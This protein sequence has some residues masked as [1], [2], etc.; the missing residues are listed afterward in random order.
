MAST[1]YTD[2]GYVS[3]YGGGIL[4]AREV[5]DTGLPMTITITGISKASTAVVSTAETNDLVAGDVVIIE[6]VAGMTEVNDILFTV[7]TVVDDTSFQ[8]AGINST[9]YTTYDSGGTAKRANVVNFGYIQETSVKYD[10]PKEDI[11]DE[12]GAIIK[13]LMGNSVVGMTGVFMQSNTTLLDFLRDS[14]EA[15]YYNIY[16]KAT[17]TNDLN[18]KTQEIFVGI[19]LFTPKFELV[20]GTRRPPFEITF[21]KNDAALTIGAPD[22]IF[23]SIAT[24]D[25]VI[26]L[27]KYYE[28]VE[29]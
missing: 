14:T 25:I 7:G 3:K 29:N 9:G 4:K 11:N 2:K 13:T 1:D 6:G 26:A 8:L 21:L 16:Y 19:A 23:G 12:T 24:A 10:K 18:A 5:L 22:V 28:I 15:K 20:S 27:A 17:P